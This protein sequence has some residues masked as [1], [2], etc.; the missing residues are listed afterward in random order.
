MEKISKICYSLEFIAQCKA[1][2]PKAEFVHQYLAD[3]DIKLGKFLEM[4]EEYC[5]RGVPSETVLEAKSLAELQEIAR[6]NQAEV[7]LCRAWRK[8]YDAACKVADQLENARKLR[9]SIINGGRTNEL[10]EDECEW[11]Y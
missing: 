5:E 2:Y 6:Q 4:R 11:E 9:R 8:E 1:V 10:D 7:A 3:G